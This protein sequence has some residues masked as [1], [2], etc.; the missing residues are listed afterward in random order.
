MAAETSNGRLPLSLKSHLSHKSHGTGNDLARPEY[1][2]ALFTKPTR[3]VKSC[4]RAYLRPSPS[5]GCDDDF[6][7][8]RTEVSMSKCWNA[9]RGPASVF[10]TASALALALGCH[11]LKFTSTPTSD[12]PEAKTDDAPAKPSKFSFRIAPYVFIS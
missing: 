12:K 4:G 5:A 7:R 6:R 3:L 8:G 11:S 10:L 1:R 2:A 9:L